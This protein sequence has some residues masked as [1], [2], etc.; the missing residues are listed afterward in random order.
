MQAGIIEQVVSGGQ[1][2]CKRGEV[3]QCGVSISA[4]NYPVKLILWL[5]CP[6][7]EARGRRR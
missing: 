4:G 7:A 5:T 6:Q 1:R 3:Y 2:D